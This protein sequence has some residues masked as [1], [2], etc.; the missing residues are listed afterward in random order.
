LSSTLAF[1]TWAASVRAGRLDYL[2]DGFKKLPL[3]VQ[4]QDER[5]WREIK[6]AYTVSPALVNLNNGGVSPQPRVVQEAV[7]HYNRMSN[8]TPSF[9]MWRILDKGR[10]PLR[11]KLANLAGC[12][13]EEIAVNRNA[14]EA[15]ETVIFGLRLQRGDEVVVSAYDYPNMENAWKQ[16]AHREGVVLK[17]AAFD[18]IHDDEET[19]LKAYTQAFS[20]NTK[21]VHIT[22]MINWNGRILPARKIAEAARKQQIEVLVDGAHSFAH[23]QYNIPD[24]QCDYF[25][26]SLHKWLCAP[27]GSGMLYVRKNKIK[28]LYPLFASP[29]PEQQDIRKFEN[30]GTRSFAIE[31][32][33]PHAIDFHQLIGAALKEQRLRYLRDYWVDRLK[34]SVPGL[35]LHTP[36]GPDRSCAL[37]L[38]SVKGKDNTK[39]ANALFRKYQIHTVSIQKGVLSGIRITPNVY[40]LEEDLDRFIAAVRLITT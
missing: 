12:S 11:S 2:L 15:L 16:R 17:T 37:S 36:G 31:Q 28:N 21:V 6:Y 13:S 8:E 30:L 32:S 3:S 33:I 1:S 14:S 19:I 18:P 27:Y 22:H 40:T 38:F 35:E 10:E 5:F 25:G 26:T 7:E 34:E 29:D 23:L 39:L 9:Y 4:V 20:R 24:L